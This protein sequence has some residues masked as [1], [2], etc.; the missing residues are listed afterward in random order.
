MGSLGVDAVEIG[1]RIAPDPSPTSPGSAEALLAAAA[2]FLSF[3]TEFLRCGGLGGRM[4]SF[5]VLRC[6]WGS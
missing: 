4:Y 2:V 5:H 1:R 3:L 6:R